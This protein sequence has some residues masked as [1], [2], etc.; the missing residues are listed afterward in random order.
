MI[1]LMLVKRQSGNNSQIVK[2]LSY[3][4]KWEKRKLLFCSFSFHGFSI[5]IITRFS[6]YSF[7]INGFFFFHELSLKHSS[8]LMETFC[9]FQRKFTRWKFKKM[10]KI[11]QLLEKLKIIKVSSFIIKKF[12]LVSLKIS[13]AKKPTEISPN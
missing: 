12:P 10:S 13:K 1:G 11:F 2:A 3:L 5:S 9:N 8:Q 7:G 6:S 4:R